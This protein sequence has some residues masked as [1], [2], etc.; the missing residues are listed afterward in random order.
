MGARWWLHK[1]KYKGKNNWINT[2]QQLL[3][4]HT[5][6]GLQS[7]PFDILT[8]LFLHSTIPQ[9]GDPYSCPSPKSFNILVPEW[10]TRDSHLIWNNEPKLQCWLCGVE[11]PTMGQR[12]DSMGLVQVWNTGILDSTFGTFGPLSTQPG[13]A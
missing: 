11:M 6:T 2:D 8:T 1:T 13:L 5:C 4:P 9:N 12:K 10:T 7:I 3:H